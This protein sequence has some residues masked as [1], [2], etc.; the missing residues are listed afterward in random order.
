[1]P[2]FAY[3]ALTED[4][5]P[6]SGTIEADSQSLLAVKLDSMGYIPL[7]IS[8]K[9]TRVSF[10]DLVSKLERVK[11]DDLIFFTRQLRAVIKAGI[12][13]IRGLKALEEQT[14]DKKLKELISIVAEDVDRGKSFSDALSMHPRTFSELYVNMV[15]VGETG[16]D[17]DAILGRLVA[18]LEFNRKTTASLKAAMRYPVIVVVALCIAFCIV[19]TFVIPRFAVIFE[20]STVKL[21]VPTRIMMLLNSMIQDYWY[22]GV[23]GTGLLAVAF[24]T[25]MRQESGRVNWD[26][27]KLEIPILGPLFLKIY[28]S[29]FSNLIETLIRSGVPIVTS[30]GIVS[31]AVGNKYVASKIR[32]IAEKVEEGSGI[33]DSL[34]Q[35][36]IF[37]PL[38]VQMASTGEEAGALD[39]MLQ[40]VTT[41]YETEIDYAV[42][43]MSSLIEPILT[44]GLGIMVLFMA[45]AIFLPWW[46]MIKVFK[47][48]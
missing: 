23:L 20:K 28:A 29:R 25:Y 47:G 21:P 44:V 13:L 19:V 6:V 38:V 10:S 31:R 2:T 40:E 27:L 22:Y 9:K 18:M 8:E 12:P 24:F 26:R 42:S 46:D 30:L 37:P 34:R 32:G 4:G 48:G 7:S 15:K 36:G 35:S 3:K 11:A 5:S 45:L 41:Y 14:E 43:R 17:L 33:G 1:M 39:D 16:G